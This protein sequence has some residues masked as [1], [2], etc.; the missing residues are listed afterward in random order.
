MSKMNRAIPLALAT[1]AVALAAPNVEAQTSNV[2]RACVNG[3]GKDG[4][5]GKDE[6]G[7]EN[8]R[9]GSGGIRRIGP[10][11]SCKKNE[12]LLVWN[13]VGPQG[14]AGLTGAQG[15]TGAMGPQGPSGPAGAAGPQGLPGAAGPAGANGAD[16]A[17]GLQGPAGAAGPQGLP[18]AVG[19]AGPA[20]ANGADGAVGPQG[21]AGPQGPAGRDGVSGVGGGSGL[22]V[23]DANGLFVGPLLDGGNVA[24]KTDTGFTRAFLLGRYFQRL[25]QLAYTT[26]DCTGTPYYWSWSNV[27]EAPIIDDWGSVGPTGKMYQRDITATPQLIPIGSYSYHAFDVNSQAWN[28]QCNSYPY[29]QWVL[30]V[31]EL[32]VSQ[33]VAPFRVQ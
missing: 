20:G 2:I 15:P 31:T 7:K 28:S 4:R 16:G 25:E 29:Q 23:V 6:K 14:P 32:N 27:A 18:G 10:T 11:E 12:T 19:P 5:N 17:V 22:S 1:L 26:P 3:P 8:E 9:D 21:L 33:F 13:V 24:L 30:P